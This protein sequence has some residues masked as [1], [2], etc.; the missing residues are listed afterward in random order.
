MA[1]RLTSKTVAHPE[2]VE[3]RG[4]SRAG[5]IAASGLMVRQAHH[6]AFDGL[7]MRGA[8]GA[9]FQERLTLSLSKGEGGGRDGDRGQRGHGSTGSP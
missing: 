9:M 5:W 6:E 2:L 8:V 4:A 7:A 3:G 1:N